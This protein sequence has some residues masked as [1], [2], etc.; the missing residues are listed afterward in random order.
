MAGWAG[1]VALRTLRAIKAQADLTRRQAIAMENAE[2]GRIT[3]DGSRLGN[4]SFQFT[5][6]N[7]GRTSARVTYARGFSVFVSKGDSLP[8]TP[9]YLSERPIGFE[10]VQWVGPGDDLE[11]VLEES[12][13]HCRPLL[14]ADLSEQSMRNNIQL[15][16]H[17]LW[18]FGRILYFDGISESERDYRFCYG[19]RVDKQDGTLYYSGGPAGYRQDY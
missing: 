5:A 6:K 13:G 10:P 18:V 8:D 17:S 4:F 7:I 2:R 14:I 9:L 1:F 3:V 11:V 16:G 15:H 12:G 19:F